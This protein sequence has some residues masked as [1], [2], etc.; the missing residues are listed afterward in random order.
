MQP[1]VAAESPVAVCPVFVADVIEDRAGPVGQFVVHRHPNVRGY[2]FPAPG[3]HLVHLAWRGRVRAEPAAPHPHELDVVGLAAVH[4][5]EFHGVLV[6][7]RFGPEAS[8]RQ[9]GRIRQS[10]LTRTK[11]ERYRVDDPRGLLDVA[12]E[13][14]GT[15]PPGP[16]NRHHQT[17]PQ[18]PV[19]EVLTE[20]LGRRSITLLITGTPL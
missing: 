18:P 13:P 9:A 6:V 3:V 2:L 16:L 10:V 7:D 12:P 15:A 19:A 11:P 17:E 4:A 8:Q 1:Q 5:D 14:A 20:V